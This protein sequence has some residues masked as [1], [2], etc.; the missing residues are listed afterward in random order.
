MDSTTN[1]GSSKKIRIPWIDRLTYFLQSRASKVVVLALVANTMIAQ[2]LYNSAGQLAL[3]S[4]FLLAYLIFSAACSTVAFALFEMSTIFQLHDLMSL[5]ESIKNEIGAT[6]LIRRGYVVLMIS[7]FINFLS[8][9]Y[10]LALA[11][12]TANAHSAAFPLDNLPAPWNYVYDAAHATAYTAVLFMAGI[13]GERPRSSKEI[14]LATSRQLEQQAFEMWRMQKEAQITQM[15]NNNQSL[16]AVAAALGSPE[17]AARVAMLDAAMSGMLS[18]LQAASLNTSVNGAANPMLQRLLEMSEGRSGTAPSAVPPTTTAFT[19]PETSPAPDLVHL[20]DVRRLHALAPETETSDESS[21][22]PQDEDESF[23]AALQ[24]SG[25]AAQGAGSSPSVYGPADE[26]L[27]AFALPVEMD[28]DTE[29]ALT[30]M[31]DRLGISRG[32]LSEAFTKSGMSAYPRRDG[33]AYN[34]VN[35]RAWQVLALVDSGLLPLPEN[36]QKVA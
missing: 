13:F 24:A 19:A 12:H 17:T 34:R 29:D 14:V 33:Q 8:V 16:S 10:F 3:S 18:S 31:A 21:T 32:A 25:K 23:L 22:D 15:G 26:R 2:L 36:I 1:P 6:K 11:W 20:S 4:R 30:G 5:D 35:I 7:S 27:K 28:L 9:F